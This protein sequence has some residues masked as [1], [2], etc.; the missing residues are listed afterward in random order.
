MEMALIYLYGTVENIQ[1]FTTIFATL[2]IAAVV[3]CCCMSFMYE[4]YF[5]RDRTDKF[6]E[7]FRKSIKP[8]FIGALLFSLLS[9]FTSEAR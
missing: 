4:D 3:V 8:T 7:L 2:F 9:I 6:R 5:N 1:S